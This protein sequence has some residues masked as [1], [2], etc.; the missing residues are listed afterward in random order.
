MCIFPDF[1]IIVFCALESVR[2]A[3]P[4]LSR[5]YYAVA[6]FVL[7]EGAALTVLSTESYR[8]LAE[9]LAS[10]SFFSA[11]VMRASLAGLLPVST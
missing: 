3:R 6:G 5:Y 11:Y 1:F 9:V 4:G 7:L 2:L 10:A 8:S